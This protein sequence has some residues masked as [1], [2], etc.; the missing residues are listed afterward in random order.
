MFDV[1]KRLAYTPMARLGVPNAVGAP[2][3]VVAVDFAPGSIQAAQAVAA[4]A[5][6]LSQPASG[7]E[8]DPR[9]LSDDELKQWE[10]VAAPVEIRREGEPQGRWL[11]LAV[12]GLLAVETV[13]RR[14]AA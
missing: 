1:V 14:R 8:S 4:I 5:E 13:M 11:W 9:T 3:L 2:L 6:V 12:I 10:R 7:S